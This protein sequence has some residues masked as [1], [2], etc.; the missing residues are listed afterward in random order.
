MYNAKA[1][2]EWRD[3]IRLIIAFGEAIAADRERVEDYEAPPR[4]NE[5]EATGRLIRQARIMG[6]FI[7]R[8]HGLVKRKVA[9]EPAENVADFL[10]DIQQEVTATVT[11]GMIAKS[12]VEAAAA[13]FRQLGVPVPVRFLDEP[14]MSPIT[15]LPPLAPGVVQSE[16]VPGGP[17]VTEDMWQQHAPILVAAGALVAPVE[18]RV[19][20]DILCLASVYVRLVEIER[21]TDAQREFATAWA[22]ACHAE[23][24][25]NV[26]E[27]PPRPDFLPEP[28]G[29]IPAWWFAETSDPAAARQRAK[30]MGMKVA[31]DGDERAGVASVGAAI[32]PST[33]ATSI[34]FSDA[35][36][37]TSAH[38]VRRDA[39]DAARYRRLR[40]LG[41]PR[42]T[43]NSEMLRFTNLDAFVDDDLHAHPSRGEARSQ[44]A[45]AIESHFGVKI[46][47]DNPLNQP[48]AAL[49]DL[50][51]DAWAVI[52]N[53]S[54][55]D[56]LQQSAEWRAA[57]QR[58]RDR[59]DLPIITGDAPMTDLRREVT[60][61]KGE[62]DH[63]Y[64]ERTRLV[65]LVAAFCHQAGF[66][67]G[68]GE[69][70]PNDKEWDPAWR[71]IVF[72][73]IPDGV[74]ASFQAS[75][76]IGDRD[77]ELV[78]YLPK[79]DKPWDGHST[80]E[81][82]L[83]IA[84]TAERL[85]TGTGETVLERWEM[86]RKF[87]VS[88]DHRG[89]LGHRTHEDIREILRYPRDGARP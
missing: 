16:G 22:A 89:G 69:H 47:A 66:P 71:T 26:V 34:G 7:H 45:A 43:D 50:A 59:Y 31:G 63:A 65:A 44:A 20:Q 46:F 60:V 77:R 13:V 28:R 39:Q 11:A 36:T 82:Y 51:E 58:W 87:L 52:A 17:V 38:I 86:A 74:G 68:L 32:D 57:A 41:V 67:V 79:Y 75:W 30:V 42:T 64:Q 62:R 70:D 53:V 9:D 81:K 61:L 33:E 25:D 2:D 83:R 8:F 12:D 6:T 73:E 1:D 19:V 10:A 23:A 84:A 24:S 35:I 72:V 18:P 78:A 21:W 40:V 76:H 3:T 55:G 48:P 14:I 5:A 49:A 37:T 56:W 80:R 88:I 85:A 54:N 15:G 4:K 29:D 27:V